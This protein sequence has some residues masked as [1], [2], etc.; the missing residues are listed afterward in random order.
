MAQPN[1]SVQLFFFSCFV[2]DHTN[3]RPD[4]HHHHHHR[5]Q[6]AAARP[7]G[8]V[9]AVATVA[10]STTFI[11]FLPFSVYAYSHVLSA[12]CAH[13]TL[14]TYIHPYIHRVYIDRYIHRYVHT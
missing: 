14:I 4:H 10:T 3:S 11:M 5:Y 1:S 7:N 2:P 13:H 12:P 9:S 8:L 6:D